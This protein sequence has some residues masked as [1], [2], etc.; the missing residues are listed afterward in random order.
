[1]NTS[2][3]WRGT[4]NL[5]TS[6]DTREFTRR[7]AEQEFGS[8]YAKDIADI[9]AQYAKYNGRRKPELLAPDTYSLVNYQEAENVVADFN[10]I[11]ARAE[12]IYPIACRNETGCVL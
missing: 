7:W 4:H 10:A 9:V 2:C 3:I 12:K 8:V 1:M 6:D 11:A 5:W